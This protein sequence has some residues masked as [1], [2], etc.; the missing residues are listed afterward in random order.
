M[1]ELAPLPPPIA[2]GTFVDRV[3][4]Q[5]VDTSA[6]RK[7]LRRVYA[8]ISPYASAAA[9]DDAVRYVVMHSTTRAVAM[10]PPLGKRST[11]G[12]GALLQYERREGAATDD[13]DHPAQQYIFRGVP[14][15][16]MP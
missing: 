7:L 4:A 14:R 10:P 3:G 11:G 16:Q 13:D 5:G 1:F 2:L 9:I 12:G 6:H 8:D 15:P